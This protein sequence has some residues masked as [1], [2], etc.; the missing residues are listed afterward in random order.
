MQCGNI[1]LPVPE[2]R[3]FWVDSTGRQER[4]YSSEEL[5]CASDGASAQNGCLGRLARP[6]DAEDFARKL[7]DV[8]LRGREGWDC[9][10]HVEKNYSWEKT[11]EK[12]LALYRLLREEAPHQTAGRTEETA[13]R[14]DETRLVCC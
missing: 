4:Q 1:I 3:H 8:F 2:N 5:L 6:G 14:G 13:G 9:R 12:L 7:S 11:F 10:R